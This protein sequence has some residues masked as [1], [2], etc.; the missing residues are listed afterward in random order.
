MPVKCKVLE[1][2]NTMPTLLVDEPSENDF[3]LRQTSVAIK[4]LDDTNSIFVGDSQV[5]G[6]SFGIRL[7]PN[8]VLCADISGPD[9]LYG[10]TDSTTVNVSVLMIY[11]E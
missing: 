10:I 8:E 2:N 11:D 9:K 3:Y 4:N 6:I 1:I 7:D 5:T